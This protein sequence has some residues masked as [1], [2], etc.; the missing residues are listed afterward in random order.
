MTE[1]VPVY[2]PNSPPDIMDG[3]QYETD[4]KENLIEECEYIWT[5]AEE[6]LTRLLEFETVPESNAHSFLKAS[7]VKALTSEFSQ[8]QKREHTILSADDEV[9]KEVEIG[10]LQKINKELE[11]LL[12]C[13]RE[14]QKKGQQDL[15]RNQKILM[16]QEQLLESLT[17]KQKE[18]KQDEVHFSEKRA[19]QDL[20]SKIGKTVL[21]KEF[22]LEALADF[23][24]EHYPSPKESEHMKNQ[25]KS[26][27]DHPST[28][29]MTMEELLEVLLNKM[30]QSPHDPYVT[31][32]D[33]MW[34]PYIETLLRYGI[35]LRHPEDPGK[36]RLEAFHQ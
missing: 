31:V 13:I 34:P 12:S 26:L 2:Q 9:L 11:L 25:K 16:E 33:S 10:E 22:L 15:E 35:T 30:K 36:I 1:P 29:V 27:T 28:E 7:S 17:L 8:W 5:E 20:Q 3:N 4:A 23:L 14:E 21:F 24:K 6:C 32:D 18:L 19:F